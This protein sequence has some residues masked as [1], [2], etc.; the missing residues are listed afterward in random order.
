[1]QD[2]AESQSRGL[3][4][5]REHYHNTLSAPDPDPSKIRVNSDEEYLDITVI[6]SVH[7]IPIQVKFM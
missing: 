4:N 2:F 7:L 6:L 1:M 5:E 3:T